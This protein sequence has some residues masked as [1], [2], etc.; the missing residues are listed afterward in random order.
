MSSGGSAAGLSVG[1]PVVSGRVLGE[2][3]QQRVGGVAQ[4]QGA[5]GGGQPVRECGVG[6]HQ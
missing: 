6:E 1:G 3:H 5:Y 4:R 2:S